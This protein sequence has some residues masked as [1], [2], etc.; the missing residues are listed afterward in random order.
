M[1]GGTR[2]FAKQTD[3][4]TDG[5]TNERTNERI[6]ITENCFMML[7]YRVYAIRTDPIERDGAAR[8][9]C[10]HLK[11]AFRCVSIIIYDS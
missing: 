6:L 3:R 4:Q 7:S 8:V 10:S 2:F 9:S 11:S 1:E 5:R